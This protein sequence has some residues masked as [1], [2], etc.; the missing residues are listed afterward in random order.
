MDYTAPP[1]WGI[2]NKASLFS[3][4]SPKY[5]H[6]GLQ[7]FM[8]AVAQGTDLLATLTDFNFQ[9]QGLWECAHENPTACPNILKTKYPLIG[10]ASKKHLRSQAA[11]ELLISLWDNDH[12]QLKALL[13]QHLL[14]NFPL[15]PDQMQIA[16]QHSMSSLLSEIFLQ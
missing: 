14:S 6:A 11:A 1:L 5:V 3:L 16:I 4:F 13:K 2:T 7:T 12:A 10:R 15:P 8:L 9:M